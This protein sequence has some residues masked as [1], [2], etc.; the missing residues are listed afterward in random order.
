MIMITTKMSQLFRNHSE[1]FP[2]LLENDGDYNVHIHSFC[3]SSYEARSFLRS[4]LTGEYSIH[5]SLK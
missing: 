1:A 4:K 5:I 2:Q 3:R